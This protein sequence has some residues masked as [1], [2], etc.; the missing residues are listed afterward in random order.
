MLPAADR[1]RGVLDEL[2]A[3]IDALLDEWARFERM[4]GRLGPGGGL[5]IL[6]AMIEAKK[7]GIVSRGTNWMEPEM[8]RD[9]ALVDA[10]VA[11]LETPLRKAF[12]QFYLNYARAEDKA[13]VCRCDV[14]TFYRR[15][16]R[17]RR[18]VANFVEIKKN[19]RCA[20]PV[21]RTPYV[22]RAVGASGRR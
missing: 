17:A 16:K 3:D 10:G 12:R 21:S 1:R 7:L 5:S 13:R 22:H 14:T 4:S 18:L 2:S 9:V 6:A 19:E 15:V 20:S 11:R 8:P